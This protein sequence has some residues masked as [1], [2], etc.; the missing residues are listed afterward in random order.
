MFQLKVQTG[1]LQGRPG[2]WSAMDT[3]K[4]SGRSVSRHI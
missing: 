3:D 4:Q 2:P 1:F